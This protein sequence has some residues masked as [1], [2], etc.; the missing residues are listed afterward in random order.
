MEIDSQIELST[1]SS[2][3]DS[4]KE[5]ETRR[6]E[7]RRDEMRGIKKNCSNILPHPESIFSH[8]VS[9]NSYIKGK[10]TT[11]QVCVFMPPKK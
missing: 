4:S 9:P 11:T 6:D 1:C 8:F 10:N 3:L 7:T 2:F 5:D